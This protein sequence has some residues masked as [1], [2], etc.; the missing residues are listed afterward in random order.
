METMALPYG[1]APRDP[2][3][4]RWLLDGSQGGTRYHNR[5]VLLAQGG[6]AF[7]PADRRFDRTR[8]PRIEAAPGEIERWLHAPSSLYVSDGD[9]DTV[10]ISYSA[11][12]LISVPRL[13]GARLIITSQP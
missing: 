5:C 3:W 2:A 4:I 10:T 8:I 7:A 11:R 1:I 12:T 13:H 9:P 6:P